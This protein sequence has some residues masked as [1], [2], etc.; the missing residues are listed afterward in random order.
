M[1]SATTGATPH[2][3]DRRNHASRVAALQAVVSWLVNRH[4]GRSSSKPAVIPPQV[5][6]RICRRMAI[7]GLARITPG[8]W[9]AAPALIHP[10]PVVEPTED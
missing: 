7:R 10:T 2:R 1:E 5:T 3:P 9:Q 8:G 6:E 4:E